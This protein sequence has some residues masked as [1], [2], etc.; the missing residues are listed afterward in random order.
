M[1]THYEYEQNDSDNWI[2]TQ[3]TDT[4]HLVTGLQNGVE[5]RFRVRAV[6]GIGRGPESARSGPVTPATQSDAPTGLSALAGDTIVELQWMAPLETGG[7]MITHYEYEQDGSGSWISTGSAGAKYTVTG[8]T[9]D[10]TYTFRVRAVNDLGASAPS[11]SESATPRVILLPPDA[12]VNLVASPGNESV[13][14]SWDQ[15]GAIVTRYEYELDGSG[16]WISTQGTTKSHTVTGLT[17]GDLYRFRVR[18]VNSAGTGEDSASRSARPAPTRPDAPAALEAEAG[19]GRVT[20]TWTAPVS[21]GGRPITHY[22]FEQDGVWETT[23]SKATKYT[24]SGLTNG[25]TYTFRV[26]AANGVGASPP[27]ALVRATPVATAA[28][29]PGGG[30]GG[31]GG[32]G[33][34]G[35]SPTE[36]DF[37]RNQA[38]EIERLAAGHVGATGMWSDGVTLWLAHNGDGVGDAVYAYDL[39]SGE[40]VEEREFPLDDANRTPRGV[41]SDGAVI[42][43]ADSVAR[44]L[45]AYDLATGERLDARDLALA[46]GN[47]SARGIWSDGE[48]V[49]V[50]DFG[51]D[52]LFAYDGASGALLAEYALDPANDSPHGL[53]FDG[54]SFWVS[55]HDLQRLFAY[56]LPAGDRRARGDGEGELRRNRDEEFTQPHLAPGR[57]PQPARHLVG[58]RRD[59]RRR[60]GQGPRLRL[61]HAR[62]HRRAAGV[63]DAER[64]RDRRVL[65]RDAGIRGRRRRGPDGDDGRGGGGA[66]PGAGRDRPARRRRGR[67]RRPGRAGGPR[68][69]P[70]DRDLAERQP[71]AHLPR[72]AAGPGGLDALPARRRRRGLQPRRLRGRQRRRPRGLRGRPGRHGPLRA[73]RRRVGLLQP[74]RAGDRQRA[75]RR[76]VRR[77][78]AAVDAAGRQ[79]RRPAVQRTRT[80]ATAPACR[81]RSACGGDVAEGFSLVV[82][83]GRQR[84]RPRGLRRASRGVA[85]LYVLHGGGWVSY[86]LGAPEIVTRGFRELFAG[87][88]PAITPL[89]AK[90]RAGE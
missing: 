85:A 82:Y 27:S 46:A 28:R 22:E 38:R 11:T 55:D 53:Y 73:A 17:N 66:A 80:A 25:Q 76:V 47:R 89:A 37:A 52:S 12:P 32:F 59:V 63:A 58:R 16:T 50:L 1:I 49:W 4:T 69:D 79:E 31:G 60:P 8:L 36:A 65:Q 30:G 71:G 84:R 44:R 35:P 74:R 90:W 86:H 68:A 21:D 48:T 24:V 9:N 13:T 33:G 51:K 6:N 78:R 70:G 29:R 41:W 2:S 43:V 72:D 54:V 3:S 5:Y 75:L 61:Q 45:F 23:E 10:Q 88:L 62:R 7:A 56:R 81:R 87:G 15:R 77:R 26:Q 20:L 19:N 64:H 34:F 14:L 57:Q 40:R 67:G 42:W 39:T 18:A 83:E